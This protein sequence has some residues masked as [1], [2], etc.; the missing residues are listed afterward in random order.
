[1]NLSLDEAIAK[2]EV[3]TANGPATPQQLRAL[4]SESK[5]AMASFTPPPLGQTTLPANYQT[6]LADVIGV[7]WVM[8][9]RPML[10]RRGIGAV[11]RALGDADT[12]ARAVNSAVR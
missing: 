1:M 6:A 5:E 2:L 7:S 8:S 4:A 10:V 9:R 3:L 11:R 12:A